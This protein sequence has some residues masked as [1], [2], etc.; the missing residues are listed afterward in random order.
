M[1]RHIYE[2]FGGTCISIILLSGCGPL[3]HRSS[4]ILGGSWQLFCHSQERCFRRAASLCGGPYRVIWQSFP[5]Q[6]TAA[7]GKRWEFT[8]FVKCE[9]LE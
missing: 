9:A 6:R 1:A 4:S 2:Y 3:A 7:F 8:A 5:D